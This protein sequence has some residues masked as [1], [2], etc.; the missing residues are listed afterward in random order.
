MTVLAV[1]R[2]RSGYGR[3]PILA[4][5]TLSVGDGEVL[6]ISVITVWERP[7]CCGP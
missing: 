6:G 7:R 2:L 5:V 3:I 4:G 1:S